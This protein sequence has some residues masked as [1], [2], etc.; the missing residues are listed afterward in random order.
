MNFL[1][2]LLRLPLILGFILCTS[3]TLIYAGEVVGTIQNISGA[4]LAKKDSGATRV[5]AKDSEINQHETL[6]TQKNTYARI[7]FIDNSE[8]TIGPDSQ[9]KVDR[10]FYDEEKPQDDN[11]VLNL[12][13][14]GLRSITGAL[15]K[16]SKDKVSIKT[17]TATIGIRGTTF[18][19]NYIAND[20][21][22]G[23]E[24]GSRAL[25]KGLYVNVIEGAIDVKNQAGTLAFAAGQ[26][27]YVS[28]FI[29]PP[30]VLPINPG[31]PFSPPPSFSGNNN[32]SKPPPA[33]AT[34]AGA[35]QSTTAPAAAATNNATEK[36]EAAPTDPTKQTPDQNSEVCD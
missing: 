15:G 25:A 7:K 27:G 19:A 16:R 13:K 9:L 33:N 22:A 26:F 17:P 4:L 30:V 31:I 6:I 24:K 10:F 8:L 32:T 11:I 29:Q 18:D 1:T 2:N 21:K 34:N 14:G 23:P 28:N 35:A 5:L 20:I 3:T 12:I 36:K